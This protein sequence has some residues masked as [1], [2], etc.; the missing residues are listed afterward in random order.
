MNK[1][2][3]KVRPLMGVVSGIGTA[4][5]G[6]TANYPL[7]LCLGMGVLV[8]VIVFLVAGRRSGV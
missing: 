5:A 2:D 1:I 3:P 4:I 6:W 7:W 8:G